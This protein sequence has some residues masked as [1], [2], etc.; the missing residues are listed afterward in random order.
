VLWQ[1]RHYLGQLAPAHVLLHRLHQPTTTPSMLYAKF[2]PLKH[3]PELLL[4]PLLLLQRCLAT[5]PC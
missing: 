4:L 2:T 5:R 3:P 1:Q